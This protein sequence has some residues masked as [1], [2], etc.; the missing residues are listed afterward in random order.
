MNTAGTIDYQDK[1]AGI[2]SAK[3]IA[4]GQIMGDQGKDSK[5]QDMKILEHARALWDSKH[6]F[7]KRRARARMYHRGDQWGDRIVDPDTG[8][9]VRE[10]EYIMSQGRVPLKQNI[11]RQLFKNLIGQFVNNPTQTMVYARNR[12]DADVSEM[13]SNAI[14][15][16]HDVNYM[17][18]VRVAMFMEYAL[19]GLVVSKQRHGYISERKTEDIIIEVP[20]VNR[21]FYNTDTEDP[22]HNDIRIIGEMH[23]IPLIDLISEFAET[24]ADEKWLRELYTENY[25][26]HFVAEGNALAGEIQDNLDF[27]VTTNNGMCR[28]IEVWLK[29][30]AWRTYEHDY[31]D[32][33][34]RITDRKD[35]EIQEENARRIMEG[36]EMGALPEDVDLIS[37]YRKYDQFWIV[38]YLT[39]YGHVL[40]EG[41]TPYDHGEHPYTINMYPGIDGEV[42]GI[43]EDIIDQQ[44]YINRAFTLM[45]FIIGASAK[46]VLLVPEESIPDDM[47]LSDF[48]DEWT[49]VNGII[50][51]RGKPGAPIPQQISNNSVPVG[52]QEMLAAQL[53]LSYDI[54]GIHQAIQGQQPRSGTP[55]SLYAQEA[56]NATI[57]IKDFMESF[58]YFTERMDNKTM[59]LIQQFYQEKKWLIVKDPNY[60]QTTRLYDPEK[61]HDV[62]LDLKVVQGP[63]T[64]VYRQLIEET[65]MTLFQAQAIDVKMLLENSSLPYADKILASIQRREEEMQQGQEGG[66]AQE[67]QQVS[68]E[69][70]QGADPR[71]M[72]LINK[73]MEQ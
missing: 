64:P 17:N 9:M 46:G 55:A 56:Q 44:R 58:S 4:P 36:A 38:K 39:P 52:L 28:V 21:L 54:S 24:P 63:D 3:K 1:K 8:D 29:S 35:E 62:L 49:K 41:E 7:R 47:E 11:I 65:L 69:V 34:Y 59:M 50:K 26:D 25:F 73:M 31:A 51:F 12:E 5:S 67:M 61:V 10:D 19:S 15:S 14:R 16:V 20:S 27:Y 2:Q 68:G 66:A 13:M 30:S 60:R 22:R 40:Y 57:N 32:G 23:D 53:K 70:Q 71:A 18:K 42:W 37:A 45:D 72:T 6:D 33:S 43:I 48:A